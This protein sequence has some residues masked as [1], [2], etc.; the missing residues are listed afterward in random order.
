MT[1]PSPRPRARRR[2]PRRPGRASR[3]RGHR[4]PSTTTATLTLEPPAASPPSR[5]PRPRAR[6]SSTCHRPKL[7]EMVTTYLDAVTRSTFTPAF[8]ARVNDIAKLG[9]EDIRASASVSNRLLDKPMAAM[10]GRHQPGVDGVSKSL[11]A[12]RRTVEDLDPQQ[13]GDLLSPRKLLGVMPF[14]DRVARLLPQVPVEPG[15]HQRDHRR[16][17]RRPGRAAPR[18][19][20]HRAGEGQPLDGHGPA[21]PVRLPGPAARR[22]H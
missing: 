19:R 3:R 13:Q 16:L 21:A 15:P 11:L 6:F 7:D 5:R 17:Y 10:A 18:Q 12:L 14:G 4:A 1:E 22:R 9:D 8:T 20:R 2:A